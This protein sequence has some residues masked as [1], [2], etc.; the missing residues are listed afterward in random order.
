MKKK[1]ADPR[2]VEV[3]DACFALGRACNLVRD[4][5]DAKR[6][7]KRAKEGY[8]EQLGPGSE[9]ALQA[10]Y[11]LIMSTGISRG[12]KIEKYRAL[13]EKMVGALGEE[14]IVTLMTLNSLGSRLAD[15]GECE[16]ARKVYERCLAGQEKVLG[17]EH[18]QTLAIR[19]YS[20]DM[21]R[22]LEKITKELRTVHGI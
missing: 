18:K 8:E 14:N 5:E 6:Y 3:L 15:N 13:V 11:S 2:K 10:T 7:F 1:K 4:G 19:E 17:G 22:S 9:K 12:E 21:K 20:R 16:E